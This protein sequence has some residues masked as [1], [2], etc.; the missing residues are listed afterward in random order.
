MRTQ[1]D[2]TGHEHPKTRQSTMGYLDVNRR[3]FIRMALAG[4][5]MAAWPRIMFAGDSPAGPTG[6]LPNVVVILADDLGFETLGCYGGRNYKIIGSGEN[7]SAEILGPVKTPNL[8]ALA[9]SGMRFTTCFACPVCSPARSELLTGQYNFRTGFVDVRGRAG[10]VDSLDP[11][12]FPTL[13]AQLKGAGYVTGISGKWHLGGQCSFPTRDQLNTNH[14]HVNS[15]GFDYQYVMP[16]SE[17][18]SPGYGK[19]KPGEYTP[20]WFHRWALK[21]VEN[22]HTRHQ[23]FFLYYPSPIPHYSSRKDPRY[24]PTPLNPD[25]VGNKNF[26]YLVEYLDQQVGDLV[27]KL[28][29]LGIR[30]NTLILTCPLFLVQ[31]MG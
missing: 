21:F 24:A 28:E 7:P 3:D 23:P 10:A 12:K 2:P 18:S 20:E 11:G 1:R 29:E 16:G 27:K 30:D 31:I 9:A 17:L 4:A 25:A 14:E 19:P 5:T 6:R 22:S 15:C 26:P 13:P 8:D